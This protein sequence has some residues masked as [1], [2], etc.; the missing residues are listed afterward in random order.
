MDN[1]GKGAKA[2]STS[3]QNLNLNLNSQSNFKSNKSSITTT[4][5]RPQFP[6]FLTKTKP[7]SL[8]NLC[9]G[10]IGRHLEDI[11]EDLDEIAIGLPAEIKL[12]VAAI[13]RRRK[14]LN[15]DV[16]IALADASWEILDVSGSDVSDLGLVKAAEVCRSVKALDISRCT[17]I[18][19]TGISELVKH[20]H[21]LETLRCGGC[22]RSD[23][24]ARR[25]LSIFKPKL[26]YVAE[27]SWEELD[28][29][30]MANG[31]QSLR[32]LV[33]PNIDNNSL[34][35]FSTECPRIVVNPKPS[36]F[37]FMGT[38]VPFE[39]FQNI[40]LDD[41]VVK[42][43]DPKTW[44]MH[45][46]AKRPISS[47]S[48]STELSVAEKFRL[49]FEERDNRLA[50]KRA[51]NARQHQRRAARDMLL[52]STS[53]KAVVLASQASKSLHSRNL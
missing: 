49:A 37:G 45:G 51:K 8:V 50:P 35:D 48:S 34:E 52:M 33:W 26:E 24:T 19:A 31:A 22:P 29:K 16:L 13:A 4:I 15:D 12:A 43:I 39:A 44:T 3:L 17:K 46:I 36:P 7:P 30:E 18:T 42:D 38:Q 9:I 25:C 41:A 28:T 1:K 2:L 6:G 32:W 14:F 10:L 53:A 11:I 23:N 47:P 27:D 20:C 21:S 40:I 5:T